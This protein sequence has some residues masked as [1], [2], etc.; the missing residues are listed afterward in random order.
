MKGGKIVNKTLEILTENGEVIVSNGKYR[1]YLDGGV[2][3]IGFNFYRSIL[4]IL[5]V[6]VKKRDKS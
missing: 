5:G 3:G 6:T 2:M 4:R 1:V